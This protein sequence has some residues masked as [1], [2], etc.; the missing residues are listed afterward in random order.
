M[1]VRFMSAV[2]DMMMCGMAKAM[3]SPCYAHNALV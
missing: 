2:M 3:L 1:N